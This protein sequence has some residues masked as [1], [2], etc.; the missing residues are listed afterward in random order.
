MPGCGSA[1]CG[2]YPVLLDTLMLSLRADVNVSVGHAAEKVRMLQ[3]YFSDENRP[4]KATPFGM[5]HTPRT[6]TFS[7]VTGFERAVAIVMHLPALPLEHMFRRWSPGPF[8]ASEVTVPCPDSGDSLC[9]QQLKCRRAGGRQLTSP[10]SLWE[11]ELNH[12][13][14][15]TASQRKLDRK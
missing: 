1:V 11:L 13:G 7:R 2:A 4:F 12:H 5:P 14:A 9:H 8:S 10:V 6:L 15:K 3:Q